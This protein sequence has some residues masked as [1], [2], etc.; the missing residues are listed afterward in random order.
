MQESQ[1][2]TRFPSVLSVF[3]AK[4]SPENVWSLMNGENREKD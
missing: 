3:P 4:K 2:I 1:D